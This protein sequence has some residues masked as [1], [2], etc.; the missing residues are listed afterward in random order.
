MRY[1]FRKQIPC[2]FLFGFNER[3][4]IDIEK[5]NYLNK[6]YGGNFQYN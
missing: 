1:D 3:V 2:F 5:N 4:V 6:W